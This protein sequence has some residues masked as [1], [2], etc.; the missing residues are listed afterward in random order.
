MRMKFQISALILLS[1]CG[2]KS[3]DEPCMDGFDRGDDDQCEVVS[4]HGSGNG[5]GGGSTGGSTDSGPD[6]TGSSSALNTPP[7]APAVAIYPDT[8]RAYGLPLVCN[9]AFQSID[10]DGDPVS[11]TVG[12]TQNGI[13][14]GSSASNASSGKTK[15]RKTME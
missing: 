13:A 14:V 12:W 11:Y 6:D 10:V 2:T 15:V 5:M 4:G 9:V 7:T 8:P 1:G 3:S